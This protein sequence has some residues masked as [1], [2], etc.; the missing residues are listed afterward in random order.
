MLLHIVGLPSFFKAEQDFIVCIATYFL[1]VHVLMDI[2]VVSTFQ[3]L[4][5]VLQ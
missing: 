4:R 3:F 2:L 1:H 5:I